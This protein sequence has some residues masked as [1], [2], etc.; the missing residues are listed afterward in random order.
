MVPRQKSKSVLWETLPCSYT[1]LLVKILLRRQTLEEQCP[2]GRESIF[3][4][5]YLHA[6]FSLTVF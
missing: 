3:N 5:W 4:H 2:E 1:N 6:S